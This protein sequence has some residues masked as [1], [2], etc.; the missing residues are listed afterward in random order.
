MSG[1]GGGVAGFLAAENGKKGPASS[2]SS[3]SESALRL[4]LAGLCRGRRTNVRLR[5]T[6]G[7][8]SESVDDELLIADALPTRSIIGLPNLGDISTDFL[9]E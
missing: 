9:E 5:E 3:A 1:W 8:C 4:D 6:G 7:S 2:S